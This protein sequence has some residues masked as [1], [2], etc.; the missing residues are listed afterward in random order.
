MRRPRHCA[1]VA[2]WMIVALALQARA[3]RPDDKPKTPAVRWDEEHPGCTFSRSEDGKYRYGLSSGD[4]AITLAVDAQEI[5]KAR[6]RHEPFFALWLSLRNRGPH[7]LQ[8][9]VEH[10]S[11]E[12]VNHFKV[13]Q[14]G[15]R[16]RCVLAE[17]TVR[18]RRAGPRNG[19][20]DPQA[21][22]T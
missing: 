7:A 9:T 12:F 21:S 11:L 6:R 13:E 14:P 16:S 17:N 2:L 10:I 18:R 3:A 4:V 20:R 19:A 1:I 5:E 15:A 8:L 22:G